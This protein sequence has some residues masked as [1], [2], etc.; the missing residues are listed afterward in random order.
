MSPTTD[1]VNYVRVYNSSNVGNSSSVTV[2]DLSKKHFAQGM[3][4]SATDNP[5]GKAGW[6]HV[7]NMAWT[8]NSD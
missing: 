5:L 6:V 3:I 8:D 1:S 7:Q 2:N 4:Y